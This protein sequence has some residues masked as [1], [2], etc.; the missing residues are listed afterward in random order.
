VVSSPHGDQ[1]T[2]GIVEVEVG[3]KLLIRWRTNKVAVRLL[4]GVGEKIRLASAP[5]PTPPM[6][7]HFKLRRTPLQLTRST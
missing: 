2:V 6:I 4:L 1:L 3:G 5:E 7:S